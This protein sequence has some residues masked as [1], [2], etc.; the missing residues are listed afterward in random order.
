MTRAL[1]L[2]PLLLLSSPKAKLTPV[3]VA[4]VDIPAGTVVTFDMISQRSV[5]DRFVTV[6]VVKPDSASYIVNQKTMVP[7][8]AG[9]VMRWSFF[10]TSK[11]PVQGCSVP[12]SSAP[13]AVAQARAR[14]LHR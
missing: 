8:L 10:E 14:V 7:V 12:A 11:N 9:D 4:A 6:S 3:V 13:A 5:E 1:L 2:A